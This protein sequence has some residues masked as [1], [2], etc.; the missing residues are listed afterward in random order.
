MISVEV[1]RIKAY[2][3]SRVWHCTS[4]TLFL[5]ASAALLPSQTFSVSCPLE[6]VIPDPIPVEEFAKHV[7]K[8]HHNKDLGFEEEYTVRTTV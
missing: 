1:A 6:I 8:Q 7:A 5:T 4:T 3:Y 2:F